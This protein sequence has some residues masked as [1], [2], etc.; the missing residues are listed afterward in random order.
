M[1]RIHASST[2][3][4]MKLNTGRVWLGGIAG[5]VVWNLWSFLICMRQA[6]LYE[7]M[8]RQ[9][10]FLAQPRYPLFMGQWIALIFVMSLFSPISTRGAA[11]RREQDRRRPQDRHAGRILRRLP[12][13]LRAGD[14]VTG[15]AHHAAGMDDGDLGR[16][17]SGFAGGGV[18]VQRIAPVPGEKSS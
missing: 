1:C 11:P 15:S 14:V 7:F 18:L 6:P 13:Q 12:Q 17:D 3:D 9:K 4:T 5:G 2:G 8:Q 16:R 10:L